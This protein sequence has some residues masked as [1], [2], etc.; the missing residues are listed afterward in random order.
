VQSLNINGRGRTET[1]VR[2]A[3]IRNR[4]GF[5]TKLLSVLR[6]IRESKEIERKNDE[7][8]FTSIMGEFQRGLSAIMEQ[9]LFEG[10]YFEGVIGTFLLMT[11]SFL[12]AEMVA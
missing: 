1:A 6:G 7:K 9:I 12:I 8:I 10:L 5:N 3:K 2:A 11:F 4:I